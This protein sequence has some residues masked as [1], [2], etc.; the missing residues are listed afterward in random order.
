MQTR[1]YADAATNGIHTKN[2][3][4]LPHGGGTKYCFLG[5]IRK[6]SKKKKKILLVFHL[7]NLHRVV[8]IKVS[9]LS[10]TLYKDITLCMRAVK[11]LTRKQMCRLESVHLPSAYLHSSLRHFPTT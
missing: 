4:S 8:K 7:L 3:M 10:S 9:F 1:G 6:T 11:I 2:N 5:K